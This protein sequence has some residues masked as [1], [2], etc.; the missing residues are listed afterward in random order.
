[1]IDSA[2]LR[3]GRFD[4]ILFVPPPDYS[5]RLEILQ[6][7]LKHLDLD[8]SID[9]PRFA[10]QLDGYT[11][12]DIQSLCREAQLLLLKSNNVKLVIFIYTGSKRNR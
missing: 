11:G 7:Y 1:L 6:M 12:A 2:L 5:E 8:S 4:V 3:P 9:M 10:A